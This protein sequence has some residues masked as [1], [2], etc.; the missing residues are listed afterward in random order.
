[1]SKVKIRPQS[2]PPRP[3]RSIQLSVFLSTFNYQPLFT[4]KRRAKADQL[5]TSSAVLL[6]AD[7]FHP[8]NRFAVQ[9]LLNGD[10]SQCG[11]RRSAVPI[12]ESRRE[13]VEVER[14]EGRGC[15]TRSVK[16]ARL[17]RGACSFTQK[18]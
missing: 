13:E 7:L 6:V 12:H 14:A 3:I 4:P 9:R 16:L 18:S 2:S 15:L 17:V 5:S 10:M 11:R 1:M 8:V